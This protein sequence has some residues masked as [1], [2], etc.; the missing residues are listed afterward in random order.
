MNFFFKSNEQRL[1]DAVMAKNLEDVKK[2]VEVKNVDVKIRDN[3]PIRIALALGQLDIVKYLISY[4]ADIHAMDD[5]GIK[6]SVY[7]GH[8]ETVYYLLQN[9]EVT[10]S[11]S[12]L[13]HLFLHAISKGL[14]D[15]TKYLISC[16]V[17][18]NDALF[19]AT[20]ALQWK[21]AKLLLETG[22]CKIKNKEDFLHTVSCTCDKLWFVKYIIGLYYSDSD[23]IKYLYN[24]IACTDYLEIMKYL[25]TCIEKY[26]PFDVNNVDEDYECRDI[27][28]I[29]HLIEEY[30][31]EPTFH[32]L[33]ASVHNKH[34]EGVRYCLENGKYTMD[35]LQEI[36]VD[37]RNFSSKEIY[38]Y[39]KEKIPDIDD[40]WDTW[41]N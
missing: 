11:T 12:Q 15:E 13:E 19:R 8:V 2:L 17:T 29:T 36:Y 3:H 32:L 34:L 22:T 23:D 38:E 28:I 14:Y 5:Q 4:G 7:H 25:I 27:A 40:N 9:K 31:V 26:E 37:V 30:K 6:L 24:S 18:S 10:L 33:M 35:D 41:S 20:D 21:I 1:C 39:F 16:K